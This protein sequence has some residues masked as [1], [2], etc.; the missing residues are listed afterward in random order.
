MTKD[1]ELK[2]V[3]AGILDKAGVKVTGLSWVP[4]V[5]DLRTWVEGRVSA[6][7]DL[8]RNC[9]TGVN[10]SGNLVMYRSIRPCNFYIDLREPNSIERAINTLRKCFGSPDEEGHHNH[11]TKRCVTCEF[12]PKCKGCGKV[13]ASGYRNCDDNCTWAY[14][15]KDRKYESGADPFYFCDLSCVDICPADPGRGGEPP[16]LTG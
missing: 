6:T 8:G 2:R 15:C 14:E 11:D 1:E 4:E 12:R 7:I 3:F 5:G 10:L 9:S 13:I 16:L